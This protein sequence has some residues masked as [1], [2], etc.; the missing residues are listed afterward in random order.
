MTSYVNETEISRS[1]IDGG[2][3]I[4]DE[5]YEQL[6]N[7]I[8]NG[9]GYFI[10]AGQPVLYSGLK[11]TVYKLVDNVIQQKEINDEDSTPDGW[12]D[13]EPTPA[14]I[15]PAVVTMRQARA[16]LILQSHFATIESA[17]NGMSEGQEKELALNEWKY[18]GTVD[19]NN[20]LAQSMIAILDLT[21]IEA[22]DLFTLAASL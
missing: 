22:D 13:V 6:R 17:L 7:S 14:V 12:Q 10:N 3:A 21:E 11:R 18:A 20:A 1:P 5:L 16:A 19:R 4:T 9:H 8:I 2:I 15:V